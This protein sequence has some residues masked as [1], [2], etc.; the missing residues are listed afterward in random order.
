MLRKDFFRGYKGYH[1]YVRKGLRIMILLSLDE[2]G[3]FEKNDKMPLFIGGVLFDDGEDNYEEMTERERIASYYEKAISDAK[4]KYRNEISDGGKWEDAFCYPTALHSEGNKERD[5]KVVRLVKEKV[6]ATLSEFLT[7]GTYGGMKIQGKNGKLLP[8]RKG[9][10]H[11]FVMLKSNNGKESLLRE[12]VSD[13]ARDDYAAN[14][15][16]HMASSVVNRLIF[17]NPLYSGKMPSFKID[18]ATRSTGEVKK[19]KTIEFEKLGF[20]K[21]DMYKNYAIMNADIYRAVIAQEMVNCGRTGIQSEG[22]FVK[23]IQY[24]VDSKKMEFLYLADSLC[25]DLGFQIKSKTI[26]EALQIISNRVN[27]LNKEKEN[28]KKANLVFGYDEIDNDFSVAWRQY[29][30]RHFFEALSIAFDAQQK[31]GAFAEYYKENWFGYLEERIHKIT[32]PKEF[33]QCVNELSGMLKS[34]ELNQEKLLYILKHFEITMDNVRDEYKGSDDLQVTMYK[35]YDAGVS[36]FCHVGNAKKAEEYY[37]KCKKEASGIG[38]DAFLQTT[39]KYVVCKEDSFEWDE[40]LELAKNT[41]DN[42]QLASEMKETVLDVH[43]KSKH[44]E[45]AKATS[46]MA[47]ILA[48][49]R[50]MEAIQYFREALDAMESSSANYKITQSYLLHFYAD[51]G[52]KEAF[53]SEANEYFDEATNYNQRLKYIINVCGQNGSIVS[54]KYALYVY[55]RGLFCFALEK[56]DDK[57]W[58]KL[59][60]L[61]EDLEKKNDKVLGGH[62]WEITYKYLEMIAIHR[63]DNEARDKFRRLRESCLEKKGDT[64]VALEM[65]GDA[66]LADYAGERSCRDALTE[67]LACFMKERF[68]V[69]ENVHFSEDGDNRY[70]ELGEYFSFMYH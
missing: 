6:S 57:L 69:F 49:M 35:L 39:N 30:E 45:E 9:E 63:K 40:A 10:Y 59:Q 42:Q 3:D 20:R 31:K 43:G 34:N 15:Y 56:V 22:F 38:V 62:P 32:N 23:S 12:S 18:L 47:R 16:F 28:K 37:E 1:Y 46:Q 24:K 13:L 61:N 4:A 27:V 54:V 53:E 52:M 8:P 60:N 11:L 58:A 67:D 65:F 17:H 2:Y 44:L 48:E 33:T 50:D 41:R 29:E 21:H 7:E 64:I 70:R 36:A 25:S 5:T 26:D 66:E 19:D 55:V 51:M 68:R 14:L